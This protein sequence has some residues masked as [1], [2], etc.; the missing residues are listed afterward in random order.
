M[1]TRRRLHQHDTT[2]TQEEGYPLIAQQQ[3][4]HQNTININYP[5]NPLFVP[6]N[7]GVGGS[8]ATTPLLNSAAYQQQQ[9][10]QSSIHIGDNFGY[11]NNQ[12]P[13]DDADDKYGKAGRQ[14]NLRSLSNRIQATSGQALRTFIQQ[15]L[16]AAAAVVTGNYQDSTETTSGVTGLYDNN[17]FTNKAHPIQE[18]DDDFEELFDKESVVVMAARDRTGEFNNAI[19]S[20]QSRNISRAVNIRDPRKA[21]QVQSYSDFMMVAKMIGKNIA[22]T[23][24]KLEKLTLLAKKKSLFD[25][26]PQEIQELTYIIKGDLN[27]LNQQIA[28]LQ[29]I[30]KDQRRTNNGKHLVS[31]SSNMVLALQSKLASM[32]TD[33]KQILEVR[34]ENLKHQKNRR[35][36][37]AQGQLSVNSVSSSTA[38]QGSL[39]LS[40]EN[41]AVSIDM[42]ATSDTQPLLGPPARIQTQ[43]QIALYDESDNYVQQRAETMQNIESTIVELGGIFQQLAHMVKEQEEIVE[44]I[45]TN[46]QDAELNIE[47]AHGEILKYFQSVSKNRWLMIKIFG[48]LIFFFIFFIVFMT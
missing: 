20:L 47:A 37:F 1:Q 2:G 10:Q 17:N 6:A 3:Q 13:I 44:R 7:G 25:D 12:V 26:R 45:D 43:Q 27:A 40:E 48:V 46:I 39:L 21:K 33:F 14:W 34:T 15:P 19:R 28:R 38:K 4:Q 22:S 24:A 8:T 36:Q 42:S 18:L 11:P 31:H 16:T 41:Q 9:P 29:E 32:S 23:Y 5:Q 30:S 35:D